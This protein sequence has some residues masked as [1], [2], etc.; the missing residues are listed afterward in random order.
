MAMKTSVI[1]TYRLGLLHKTFTGEK[2]GY[3]NQNFFPYGKV[4][5]KIVLTR[6]FR[7]YQRFFLG[8]SYKKKKKNIEQMTLI[9][10]L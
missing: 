5:G 6:I 4:N 7:F 3:F 1:Y 8:L 2:N 10:N 9:R